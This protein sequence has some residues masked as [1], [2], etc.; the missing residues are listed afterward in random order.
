M[1]NFTHLWLQILYFDVLLTFTHLLRH[2]S[3][4]YLFP[5]GYYIMMHIL[6]KYI[7]KYFKTILCKKEVFQIKFGFRNTDGRKLVIYKRQ[8]IVFINYYYKQI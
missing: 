1:K 8:N 6:N 3:C 4:T 7:Y 2:F 5:P